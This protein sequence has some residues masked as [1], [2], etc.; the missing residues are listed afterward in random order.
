MEE[1]ADKELQNSPR[2]GG[3]GGIPW[4]D[5]EECPNSTVEGVHSITVYHGDQI[6]GLQVT[7]RL[8]DGT[9]HPARLHGRRSGRFQN[10]FQLAPGEKIVR[11]EGKTNNVLVDRLSFVTRS[12]AGSENTYGPYGITGDTAF[13]VEGDIVGFFGRSG[14]LL[15]ALGVHYYG[16]A[17][18]Q[19]GDFG[20]ALEDVNR[21]RMQERPFRYRDAAFLVCA[22]AAL[23]VSYRV[24][25]YLSQ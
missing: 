1:K 4:D 13:A 12:E 7:Y 17:P 10:S 20:R 5:F 15:D 19:A 6:D 8:A 23:Y 3:K 25:S 16:D 21:Q 14:D 18:A 22:I 2:Y 9:L 24:D 11:V